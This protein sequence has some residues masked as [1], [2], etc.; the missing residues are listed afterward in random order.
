MFDSEMSITRLSTKQTSIEDTTI[1]G[2]DRFHGIG[3][4]LRSCL[5]YRKLRSNLSFIH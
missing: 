1:I 3:T 2:A 5:A 4:T